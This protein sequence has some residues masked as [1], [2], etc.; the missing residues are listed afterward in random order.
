[1]VMAFQQSV[2]LGEYGFKK[3]P[4]TMEAML[5]GSFLGSSRCST[6]KWAVRVTE[7]PGFLVSLRGTHGGVGPNSFSAARRRTQGAMEID[8]LVACDGT[9]REP[10]DSPV[11]QAGGGRRRQAEA[12]GGRRGRW[13]RRSGGPREVGTAVRECVLDKLY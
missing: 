13:F 7:P 5:F 12:G 9:P 6:S 1:M 11:W 4:R 3:P 8:D 10:E 2:S